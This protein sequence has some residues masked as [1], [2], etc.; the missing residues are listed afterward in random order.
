MLGGAREV[1]QRR[2]AAELA[3]VA[4]CPRCGGVLVARVGRR[5]PYFHCRCHEAYGT[6]LNADGADQRG[7]DP[8]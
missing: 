3:G 6:R 5:G 8:R 2:D 1:R 4:R 7:P